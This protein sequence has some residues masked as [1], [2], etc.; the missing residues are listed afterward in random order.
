[1]TK[2]IKKLRKQFPPPSQSTHPRTY[3]A[4][5]RWIEAVYHGYIDGADGPPEMDEQ[6]I[7]KRAPGS[8][9]C[10]SPDYIKETVRDGGR[11]STSMESERREWKRI[12]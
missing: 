3:N 6:K 7:T 10:S 4:Y 2:A 1:M 9:V 12:R 11:L 8:P 5:K